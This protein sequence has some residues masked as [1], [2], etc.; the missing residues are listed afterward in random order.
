MLR[1]NLSVL[2]IAALLAGAS[3]F[4]A[5]GGAP[6]RGTPLLEGGDVSLALQVAPGTSLDTAS[7]TVTGPAG[8][9]RTGTINLANSA[10]LSATVGGVP[11][12]EPYTITITAAASGL[13]CSGTATFAVLARQTTSVVVSLRCQEAPRT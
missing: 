8:F 12:G 10:T 13:S 11:A 7:Y 6:K 9:S 1:R 2:G 4:V 3:G 5:C